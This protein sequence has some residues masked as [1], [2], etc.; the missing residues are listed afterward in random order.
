MWFASP[1][2]QQIKGV[3]RSDFEHQSGKCQQ[4]YRMLARNKLGIK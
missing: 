1:G 2:A 3:Q 4:H